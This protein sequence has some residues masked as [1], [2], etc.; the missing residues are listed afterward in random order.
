VNWIIPLLVAW[1]VLTLPGWL[2]LRAAGA[3]VPIQWG[4]A[5]PVTVLAIVALTG[6]YRLLGIPWHAVTVA[7]G[8]LVLVGALRALR[9]WR[10]G[11][12][13]RGEPGRAPSRTGASGADEP[14]GEEGRGLMPVRARGVVTAIAMAFGVLLV[15]SAASR[16]GG[17]DTLNGSYDAFFHHSSIAFIR[18]SGDAFLTT[19]LIDIYG[20]PTFYPVTWAV[21]AALLPFGTVASANAMMLATLA[22]LP[23]AIAAMIASV[24]GPRRAAAAAAAAGA[25][26][27]TLFLSTP[28]MALVMGLWPIV[29]GV[30]CLPVALASVIRLVDDPR[31]PLRLPAAAGHLAIIAGTALAHPSILFSLAVPGGVLLL[32]RGIGRVV[33]D[34]LPRRGMLQ[35]VAAL[36]GAGAFVVLSGTLLSGMHLTRPSRDPLAAVL[37][38]ILV[39][40]PRIPVIESPIWPVAALW[41]L[42]AIGAAVTM[43]RGEEIGIAAALGAVLTVLLGLSTQLDNPLAVALVNPWYGA[44]ERIAPLMMCLLLILVSRAVVALAAGRRGDRTAPWPGLVALAVLM[45]TVLLALVAPARLPLMGSLAYTNYGAQLSP[46]APPEEREFIERTAADLPEDAVVLADPRDGATLYWSL[47]G[48]ETVYPTMATPQTR[49]HQLIANY[50]TRPDDRREICGALERIGP[51]HLYRDSSEFSGPSLDPEASAPWKGVHDIPDSAL[52]LVSSQGPYA[53]YELE[54]PC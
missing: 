19:A 38:Q 11:S 27:S 37:R 35:A 54:L 24:L 10:L 30:L 52:T 21:L 50:I 4:W 2:L 31:G 16:M 23:T 29:L 1:G 42:A 51:T 26:A 34:D 9:R 43:R 14:G 49:D 15:A 41:I 28:A 48:V 6:L 44:R 33:R 36:A 40:S 46:Y 18:D 13:R 39:D 17:I 20:E 3:R 25:A 32:V 12:G 47:G 45:L 53:L 5:P 22:A 7:A 8:V